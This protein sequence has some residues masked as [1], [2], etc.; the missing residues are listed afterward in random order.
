MRKKWI[1]LLVLLGVLLAGSL[2]YRAYHSNYVEVPGLM[3]QVPKAQWSFLGNRYVRETTTYL[4]D[5]AS[6]NIGKDWMYVKG[7]APRMVDVKQTAVELSVR[8]A[9]IL[10][11]ALLVGIIM[12]ILLAASVY[13]L[14]GTFRNRIHSAAAVLISIPDLLWISVLILLAVMVDQ[15]AGEPLIKIVELKDKPIFLVPFLSMAIPILIYVF[16]HAVHAFE[17]AGSSENVKYAYSRG[18]PERTVF[19]KYILRPA[20]DSLLNVIPT[21]TALAVSNLIVI[22]KI[23]NIRGVTASIG[24]GSKLMATVLILLA[25]F[26]VAVYWITSLGKMWVNPIRRR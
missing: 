11:P 10:F 9:Q 15:H 7:A 6:G 17:E 2:G 23:Y 4:K 3:N 18:L 16:F 8:S 12:G 5:L 26:I 22:E 20:A 24:R 1:V 19:G 21:I 13:F 14:P 25:L